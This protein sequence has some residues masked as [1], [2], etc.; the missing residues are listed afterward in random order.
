MTQ[1]KLSSKTQ[2]IAI[3]GSP[4]EHSIT[5]RIQNAAL[6][7]VGADIVNV[8]FRVQPENLK[9]AVHGARALG[10]LGLMVTIPHKEAVLELCDE[11]DE[12]A[13]LMGAA[14]LLHFAPDK[15]VGYS[16][17]GWAALKSLEEEGVEF[18]GANITII[19]GGGAARSLALTFA[20]AGAKRIGILNRTVARAEV[21]AEETRALGIDAFAAALDNDSL[22]EIL[23]ATDILVNSTSVGMH[24]NID[25]TPIDASFLRPGLA[26]YDIVYNPLETRLLREAREAGARPVDGL[27]MLIYTNVRAVE[28]CAGLDVSAATMRVEALEALAAH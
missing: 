7:E 24:P 18:H 26:V 21:I 28:I 2:S 19:G 23:P 10:L 25:E 1:P 15:T 12:S 22:S 11:L 3:I 6:R 16:S 27:G 8:A 9:E 5:P 20:A 14:N 17:D 4:I 13:R